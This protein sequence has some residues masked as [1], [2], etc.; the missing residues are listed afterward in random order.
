MPS[1]DTSDRNSFIST[2]KKQSMLTDL[3]DWTL[4]SR[5]FSL[6]SCNI[7]VVCLLLMSVFSRCIFL[8]KLCYIIESVFVLVLKIIVDLNGNLMQTDVSEFIIWGNIPTHGPCAVA[9]EAIF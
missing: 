7:S 4:S 2:L 8:L 5:T 3:L 6:R 9:R 1:F